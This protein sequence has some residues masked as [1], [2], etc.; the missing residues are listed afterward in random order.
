MCFGGGSGQ[1]FQSV[2]DKKGSIRDV[3]R[4]L[5]GIDCHQMRNNELSERRCHRV[6]GINRWVGG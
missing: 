6:I 1:S 4:S 5:L 3:A 2:L